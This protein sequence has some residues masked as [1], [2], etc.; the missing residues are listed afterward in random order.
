MEAF[1]IL[2]EDVDSEIVLFHD[3]FVHCQHYAEAEHNVTITIP[4]F[5]P[6][7]PNYYNSV[8]SDRWLHVETCLPISF[9]H[10]IFPGK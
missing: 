4:M 5:E 3:T 8:V 10:L 2:V 7:P 9:K 1:H 6:V